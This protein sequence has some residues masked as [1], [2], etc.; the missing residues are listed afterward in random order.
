MSGAN[1]CTD[2]FT[3]RISPG[4]CEACLVTITESVSSWSLPLWNDAA[5]VVSE[6]QKGEG[7]RRRHEVDS[8]HQLQWTQARVGFGCEMQCRASTQLTP[9]QIGFWLPLP[10]PQHS[11]HFLHFSIWAL[12]GHPVVAA[13]LSAAKSQKSGKAGEKKGKKGQSRP[14]D[15]TL[16][17]QGG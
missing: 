8:S 17:I 2:K 1:A 6:A 13:Q 15:A 12:S 11:T 9:P 10:Q 3:F 4:A 16:G 5:V 14:E 7:M